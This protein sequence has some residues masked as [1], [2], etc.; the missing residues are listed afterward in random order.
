M[1]INGGPMSFDGILSP[2]FTQID[3]SHITL[4]GANFSWELICMYKLISSN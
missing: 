3:G 4:L 2:F 1:K